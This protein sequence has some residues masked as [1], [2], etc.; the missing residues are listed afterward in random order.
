MAKKKINLG[1]FTSVYSYLLFLLLN[2]YNEDDIII[3]HDSFPEEISRNIKPIIV[4]VVRFKAGGLRE[5]ISKLGI[6]QI[7]KGIAIYLYNYF[8]LRIF[9]FFK[10]FNKNVE[11]YGHTFSI[12]SYMFYTNKNSNIIEDGLANYTQ[13]ICKPHK[14]N[15]AIEK[16][17]HFF[18]VYFL[19]E[20]ETYGTH[21][22]IKNVYLTKNH[23]IP[24][25]KDKIKVINVE[26]LWKELDYKEKDKILQIFN[27]NYDNITFKNN[28]ALILTQPFSEDNLLTLNQELCIYENLIEKFS[29]YSIII[30]P[31]PRDKKNY[32][33]IF[34]NVELIDSYFPIELLNLFDIN[35]TIVISVTTASLLNFKNCKMYVYEGDLYTDELNNVRNEL[36]KKINEENS[37]NLI[38]NIK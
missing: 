13:N 37:E 32:K 15:P 26:K 38:R 4:P 14:I 1:L 9:L 19:N 33:K 11:N 27:I 31:H 23:D 30:K 22:C 29:D 20:C 18:G 10:T 35:P 21:E 34:S 24:L 2:G 25:I 12:Y 7:I 16:I 3:V 5:S 8:K 28:T 36:L 6:K 17:L